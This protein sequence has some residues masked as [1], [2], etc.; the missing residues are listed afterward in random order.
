[1]DRC[2]ADARHLWRCFALDQFRDPGLAVDCSVDD[3]RLPVRVSKLVK[4]A[5]RVSGYVRGSRVGMNPR[6][7]CIALRCRSGFGGFVSWSRVGVVGLGWFLCGFGF[8]ARPRAQRIR[9]HGWS[10]RR[11]WSTARDRCLP[12]LVRSI[13]LS[14]IEYFALPT[15]PPRVDCYGV[16]AA[17]AVTANRLGRGSRRIGVSD[18]GIVSSGRLGGVLERWLARSGPRNSPEFHAKIYDSNRS[19]H[20]RRLVKLG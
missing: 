12:S 5:A 14:L 18:C 20:A 15:T 7:R 11:G 17:A 9:R 3:E 1:V 8:D 6:E 10:D 16:T 19:G 2:Y 4:I 13:R